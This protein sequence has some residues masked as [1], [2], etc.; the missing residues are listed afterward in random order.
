[1]EKRTDKNLYTL[2]FATGMVV[3]VGSLL[4][5]VASSL[6]PKINENKRI[7][8]QQNILYAMGVHENEGKGNVAFIEASKVAG[9]FSKYIKKQIVITGDLD[10]VENNDAY[11]IDIKKR[12][13]K[14]EGWRKTSIAIIYW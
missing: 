6:K 14:I 5:F 1:M 13:N 12:T 4:A 10:I 9:E 3:V 8:K 11:L 7:E 2:L